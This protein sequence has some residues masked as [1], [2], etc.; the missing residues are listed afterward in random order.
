MPVIQGMIVEEGGL[1]ASLDNPDFI[2]RRDAARAAFDLAQVEF[3]RYEQLA[4]R[5]AVA[6]V[7]LDRKRAALQAAR[8]DLDLAEKALADTVLRAPFRGVVSQR[9]VSQFANIEAKQPIVQFQALEPLNVV[10]DIP[11]R[12]VIATR[13]NNGDGIKATVRFPTMDNLELPVKFRE[14]STKADPV[15]Q[16]FR[17]VWSLDDTGDTIVLPGMSATLVAQRQANT[18]NGNEVFALPP[19]S[20]VGSDTDAP[21]VWLFDQ[22][23]GSVGKRNVKVGSLREE[24][25]EI[26]SGLKTG[27]QVVVAGV[28]QL[29]ADMKVRPME[30][31]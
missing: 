26:L 6:A 9:I 14:I 19:L 4:N 20:V 30:S 12:L 2:S 8:S 23:T 28:S 10:I 3:L 16:T 5:R 21:Y 29:A 1:L 31:R 15:T 25:L 22:A 27:D 17:V 13:R 18:E 7:E 24:G 11:E